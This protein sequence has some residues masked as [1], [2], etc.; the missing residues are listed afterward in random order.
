METMMGVKQTLDPE[1]EKEIGSIQDSA[2]RY[3]VWTKLKLLVSL[4]TRSI[5]SVYNN[6]Y[7]HVYS[8]FH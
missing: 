1:L 4:I 8:L 6:H 5:Y 2:P 7:V 3:S